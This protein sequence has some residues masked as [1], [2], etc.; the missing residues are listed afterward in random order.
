MSAFRDACHRLAGPLFQ[1]RGIAVLGFAFKADTSDTRDSPAIPVCRQLLEEQ[2]HLAIHDPKAMDNAQ[3]DL[4]GVPGRI[5]FCDDPY[6]AAKGAHAIALLTDW[7][8]FSDLDFERI[9][10]SMERPAFVFDGR[11]CLDHQKLYEI[12]FNVFPVG[13]AELWAKRLIP[14]KVSFLV[15][16]S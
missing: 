13:K 5:D 12:G 15:C 10:A 1:G 11:N 8:A 7:K 4:T 3:Q 2:A 6:E 9:Y 14:L 16:C